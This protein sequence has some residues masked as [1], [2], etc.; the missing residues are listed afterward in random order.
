MGRGDGGGGGGEKG[1]DYAAE[2]TLARVR[3]ENLKSLVTG[4]RVKVEK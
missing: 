3:E 4:L 2:V 1:G